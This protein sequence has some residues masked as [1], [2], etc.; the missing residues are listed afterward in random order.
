MMH[1]LTVALM[2]KVNSVISCEI[3]QVYTK[4]ELLD[5]FQKFLTAQQAILENCSTMLC[6]KV[7]TDDATIEPKK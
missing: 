4:D 5:K 1:I 3:D 6:V 2:E 7:K